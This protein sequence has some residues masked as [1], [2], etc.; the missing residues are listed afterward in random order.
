MSAVEWRPTFDQ[1]RL[2]GVDGADRRWL[3]AEGKT[4]TPAQSVLAFLV[5]ALVLTVTPGLDTALF[6]RTFALEGT[7][8][9]ATAGAGILL[10]CLLWG[11]A[12]SLGVGG[13]LVSSAMAF[14]VVKWAGAA[15]LIWMGVGMI[16]SPRQSFDI[17]DEGP[18][19]GLSGEASAGVSGAVWFRRGLLTDLLNPKVG[20]F[21]VSFLPQ[22][23]PTDGPA[24]SWMLMLTLIQ[25]ALGALWFLALA[26]AGKPLLRHLRRPAVMRFLDRLTGGVLLAFGVRL[27]LMQR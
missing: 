24:T 11:A 2:I 7:R 16:R 4:M 27:A 1:G 17:A 20:V 12:V 23:V 14:T 5:A 15:Y 8:R 9:A 3:P 25:C 19:G 6:L 21:F 22:F 26:A 18:S 13:L 10:G